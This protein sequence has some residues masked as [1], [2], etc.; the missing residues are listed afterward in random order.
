MKEK[1]LILLQ[2]L[3]FSFSIEAQVKINEVLP[4]SEFG[5]DWVELYNGSDEIINLRGWYLADDSEQ[6]FKWRFPEVKIQP[7]GHL[8]I[9]A[10]GQNQVKKNEIHTSFKLNSNGEILWLFNRQKRCVDQ[11]S[12]G[13]C[14][15]NVSYGRC[16]D[17]SACFE[18]FLTPSPMKPNQYRSGI[19]FSHQ[20]GIFDDFFELSLRSKIGDTI[21]Y[22]TDGSAPNI[23][24]KIYRS[25]IK[26]NSRM[27]EPDVLTALAWAGGSKP[28]TDLFKGNVIKAATFKNGEMTSPIYVKTYFTYPD[29]FVRYQGANIVSLI[30]DAKNLFQ[31]DSGLYVDGG[32]DLFNANFNQRGKAWEREAHLICFNALGELLIDQGVRIR[33]HGQT[34]R[35][36]PSK[37]F[38]IYA[39]KKAGVPVINAPVFGSSQ[40]HL[41]DKLILRNTMG[42]PQ[43]T[44]FKDE[45]TAAICKGLNVDVANFA[46]CILFINGEYWG[47]YNLREYLGRA[48]IANR[49]MVPKDSVNITLHGVGNYSGPDQK[50]NHKNRQDESLI[51]LYALLQSDL[52]DANNYQKIKAHLNI[53]SIIDFYCIQLFFGNTDY[54]NNNNKLWR[55][56]PDGQWHQFLFD[57]DV[58]W[59]DPQ[60]NTIVPLLSEK[61][62]ARH[63]LYATLLFRKLVTSPDFKIEFLKRFCH[64][65]HGALSKERLID[66]IELFKLNYEPLIQEHTERWRRPGSVLQWERKVAYLIGFAKSRHQYIKQHISAAFK[67]EIDN[68]CTRD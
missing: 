54:L 25:P 31:K 40:V 60:M 67:T 21:R 58:G 9:Y 1:L 47:I 3:L 36:Y 15:Q 38:R 27:D 24:A 16:E 53:A 32:R 8:V 55:I 44:L 59:L 48:Y 49:Y 11:V 10:S 12:F 34:T 45:C 26:I 2:V 61:P 57:L 64:L 22:T 39:D 37:S 33:I 41:F 46:H 51:K 65:L 43:K 7:K 6:H 20:S 42:D 28:R 5:N 29:F 13:P 19:L 52:S 50:F 66:T 63:P 23:N 14:S 68:Y 4:N 30:T 17:G 18:R 62:S 35:K 56:L